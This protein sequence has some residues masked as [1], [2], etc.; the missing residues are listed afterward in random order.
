MI[1]L[2]HGEDTRMYGETINPVISG[3]ETS[4]IFP[5]TISLSLS[6]SLSLS[7]FLS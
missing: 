4:V 6:L 5:L 3:M 2:D 1:S 7:F